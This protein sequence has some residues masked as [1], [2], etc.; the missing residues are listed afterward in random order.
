MLDFGIELTR[1]KT[2]HGQNL[3]STE[4]ALLYLDFIDLLLLGLLHIG[5]HPSQVLDA[6]LSLALGNQAFLLVYIRAVVGLPGVIHKEQ[7]NL[8]LCVLLCRRPM[9]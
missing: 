1:L 4:V 2:I 9:F 3:R 6:T 7:I 8:L 5:G